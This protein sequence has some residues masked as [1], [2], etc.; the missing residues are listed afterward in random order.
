M[1]L[2]LDI[3]REVNEVFRRLNNMHRWNSMITEAKYNELSKQALNCLVAYIIASYCE[4]EGMTIKWERFPRI[5]LYRAFNRAYVSYEIPETLIKKI[6]EIGNISMKVFDSRTRD[7]ISDHTNHEFMMFI[8]NECET[9]EYKIF[10]A[11]TKIATYIELLEQKIW[12]RNNEEVEE[13]LKEVRECLEEFED[14]K[15]V[16]EILDDNN[17]VFKI[18]QKISSKLR[19]SNRWAGHSCT[20]NNSVLGHLFDTAVFAYFIALEQFNGNEEL[21][22]KFFFMGIFHDGAETWTTDVPSD[23]KDYIVGF[24]EATELLEE[25]MVEENL[26]E[27]IP[28]FLRAK[29]KEVMYEEGDN[30]KYKTLMKGADYLSADSECCRQYIGGSRDPYFLGNAIK[31]FDNLLITGYMAKL[32]PIARELHEELKDY[33]ERIMSSF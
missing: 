30:L 7:R 12:I 26:Y 3:Y 11:G 20:I 17:P 29:I 32:T 2:N 10:R 19:N 28:D 5:A 22:T 31:G 14:I 15:A 13:R 6:C 8:S 21:A 18:I 24:R 25:M 4:K 27:M 9:M 16:K 23:L 33:A 1:K